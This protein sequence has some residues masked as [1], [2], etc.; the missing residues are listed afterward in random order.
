MQTTFTVSGLA[1]AV[2]L[3]GY[4][5][6]GFRRLV[7]WLE[8]LVDRYDGKGV[9]AQIKPPTY[10]PGFETFDE[11]RR[12][13]AARRRRWDDTRRQEAR[14]AERADGMRLTL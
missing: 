3:G 11:G 2:I 9:D 6:G 1:V 7:D 12:N 13:H 10:K 4:F 8:P 5:A 14:A